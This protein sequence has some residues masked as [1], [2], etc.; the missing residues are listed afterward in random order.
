MKSSATANPV[1]TGIA[2]KFMQDSNGFVGRRLFPIFNAGLQSAAYYVFDKANLL[3]FPQNIQRAPGTGYS[4]SLMKLSDDTF[5]CREYG[6]EEPVDDGER[7]KYG[8]ALDADAAATR[9]A[10]NVIMCNHEIRVKTKATA[11]G[12]PTSTPGTKWD[13]ANSDPVGDVDVAKGTI[14]QG[15]GMPA[16]TMLINWDN[17][18]ILKEHAKVTDKIKYTQKGIV[19]LDMLAGVFGVENMLLAYTVQNTAN[20]GQAITPS[21]IWGDAV[22]LAHVEAAQ[23]LMSPNFGRTFAWTK[24][25]GQDGVL[26]DTYREDKVKSDV[27]RAVQWTDEKMVGTDCGFYLSNTLASV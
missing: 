10:T 19:T 25:T 2:A 1:M 20:E 18:R 3:N 13:Q 26:V 11:A 5:N 21:F 8:I 4:R 16:N 6:H 14:L 23:D 12:V 27:H 22:I 24:F 15:C 9:R 17:F 7:E